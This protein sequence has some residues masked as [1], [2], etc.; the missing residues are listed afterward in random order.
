MNITYFKSRYF[1]ASRKRAPFWGF[2]P[3]HPSAFQPVVF[4]FCPKV[5]YQLLS[6]QKHF[7][8]AISIG[9]KKNQNAVPSLCQNHEKLFHLSFLNHVL[10]LFS[11]GGCKISTIID[12]CW[13]RVIVIWFLAVSLKRE[14][15]RNGLSIVKPKFS[16]FVG[17]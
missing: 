15:L 5:V 17:L 10:G 9:R 13:Y 12:Q 16:N 1:V 2:F 6:D 3:S 4:G 11:L 8:W 7:L 14:V